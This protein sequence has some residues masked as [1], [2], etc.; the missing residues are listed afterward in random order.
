LLHLDH[1]SLHVYARNR[2][3]QLEGNDFFK[4]VYGGSLDLPD[5]KD[6]APSTPRRN[7]NEQ[8]P[9]N[10]ALKLELRQLAPA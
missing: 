3:F 2:W 4:V 5:K 6:A 10:S 8:W 1:Y 9:G 7:L